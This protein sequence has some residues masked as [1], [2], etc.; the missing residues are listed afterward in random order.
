MFGPE[1]LTTVC[2]VALL[3]ACGR[4][5]ARPVPVPPI[6]TGA[7]VVSASAGSP[8]PV[9][10]P[11]TPWPSLVRDEQW[12]AA[13]RALDA[14]PV[15]DKS[16]PEVRYVRS[17]VAL[18][19]G[20]AAAA[21]P[22]LEGLEAMLP[23]LADD[24]G[25]RRAEAQL[26]VGPFVEAGEWYAARA[27]PSSQLDAARA[28]EKAR[29]A[30]RS[31]AAA[32]R[33]V[34][35]DRRTRAQEG[36]ARALRVRLA[37]SPG[38]PQPAAARWPATQGADLAAAADGLALVDKLEP[39][40]PL[41][42]QE[43]FVRARALSEAGRAD[44]AL[45]AIEL[46]AGAPGADK[47]TNLDRARARATALYSARGRWSDAARA[48]EECAGAGGANAA[49]DAFH[50]A[51]AL[52][53][54]DRDE[55]AIRAYEEVQRRFPK[56]T[57]AASAAFF[58]PY[59]RML[60]GDWRDCARGFDV[61]SRAHAGGDEASDAR[62]DGALCKLLDGDAKAARAALE[63][64]VEDEPDPVVSARMADMAALAALHDGD[65][66]HAVARWTDVARSRPLSW[67]ALVARARLVE[68]GAP[69]PPP[70]DPSQDPSQ[71]ATASDPPPLTTAVP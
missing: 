61:Y 2:G 9:E 43:L 50:A 67:P 30:R 11:A 47:V 3:A 68:V 70:I 49:E 34:A 29:D 39:R 63:R 4:R 69:V 1:R 55:E 56:S 38:D 48:L 64:L 71:D 5:D 21:L 57:W 6:S 37:E 19:R 22:L 28:F 24:V 62:R 23:L 10:E 32:D 41:T 46:V 18:V 27:T 15:A 42:A 51:R 59:L 54:A 45:R 65:R 53:R 20:D 7:A 12:D 17:R 35:S 52:S 26:A 16:R 25:R 13:W 58:V 66:T 33:V 60:H 44:D 40:H 8:T 14:L 31:R 36:E